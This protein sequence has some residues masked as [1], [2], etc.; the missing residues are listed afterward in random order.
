MNHLRD[1]IAVVG[2]ACRFP[3][4]NSISGLWALLSQGKCAVTRIPPDR[5]SLQHFGHPRKG[6][7]G[8]S[9][10]WAAGVLDDIWAFDP[11]VFG[12]SPREAEQM[13]PQQRILLQLTWEALEDAGI[14]PSSLAGTDVG[15]FVGGSL[16]EHAHPMYGDPAIADS[17][18]ATGNA[19]AILAN[20]ISYIFDLRGPSITIDTACSSS[21]VAVNQAIQAIEC[22]RIDTAIVGGINAMTA[23]TSFVSF[24][25]ASMLSPTG[26]CRAFSADAD[27]YVRAEGGGVVV[28]R[29]VA[30]ARQHLNPVHGIIVACDVSSDGRTNGISLP[31][32]QAQENL[33]QRIYERAEV[34]PERLAFVEA[35]GTGTPAGDPIEATALGNALG[36]R[37]STPLPIGSIKTNIGHLEPASGVAGLIKSL[38]AL[39]NGVL[40]ASLHFSGPNPNINF[41]ALNLTV[42][43]EPLKLSDARQQLAGVNSFGFGGTNAHLIL[44]PGQ[45][46]AAIVDRSTRTDQ[47]FSFS[48]ASRP[49]L[50]DFARQYRDK[51][52]DLSDAETAVIASA[53]AHRRDRLINRVVVTTTCRADVTAALDAFISGNTHHLLAVG[54][55][56]G[57]QLPIAFVYSGNGSQWSGMGR[58]SYLNS[59]PFRK[60]FDQI[61]EEFSG[62]AGWSLCEAIFD[63]KL[64]ERLVHTN[65]AQPLIF[66]IQSAATFALR[67]R[68]I[69]PV[70]I[71]GHSVGE[72]AAAEA[73][74]IVDL[75]SAVRIIYF[76]SK[77]QE[78]LRN[79]GR[80]AAVL[81]APEAIEELVA[82]FKNIEIAAYNGPRAVTIAGPA[83]TLAQFAEAA[84]KQ[85][86]PC[87]DLDLDYP[88]HT[89]VM[90]PIQA[91]LIRDLAGIDPR[92]GEIAFISTV[93]GTCLSGEHLDASYWW[94]NVREPVR[95]MTAVRKAAEFGARF[96]LEIGPRGV[97]IK[98]IS[99]TLAAEASPS[100]ALSVHERDEPDSI[101]PYEKAAAHVLVG[102]G[103]ID[104]TAIAGPDPG[105]SIQL[106]VYPWQQKSFRLRPTP[107]AIGWF[108]GEN[109]PLSG[110]RNDEDA[111]EWHAQIDIW[112]L[113]ELADHRLGEKVILPGTGFVEIALSVARQ[114]LGSDKIVLTDFETLTP[115]DLTGGESRESMT[116]ISSGSHTFEILSRPRLSQANWILHAR[117]KIAAAATGDGDHPRP[118][119]NGTRVSGDALY[120]IADATGLHY[121]PAFSQ[122]ETLIRYSNGM[123]GVELKLHDA[124]TPFMLD[125]MLLDCCSQGLILLF[126]ELQAEQRG[127]AYIPVRLD[128]VTLHAA[129]RIPQRSVIEVVGKSERSILANF[130]IF[131]SDDSIVATLRGVRCQAVPVRRSRTLDSVALVERT[132]P[133]DGFILGRFGT[134]A[135]T[136]EVVAQAKT[137]GLIGTKSNSDTDST[138]LLDG[139]ATMVGYEIA[140]TLADR[141]V[142]SPNH[143]IETNRISADLR[144]W[145][146]MLLTKLSAAGLARRQSSSWMLIEDPLLPSSASIIR[147][148]AAR[149]PEHAGK[150]LAAAEITGLVKRISSDPTPG[151]ASAVSLSSIALNFYDMVELSSIEANRALMRLLESTPQL[152]PRDRAIRVLQIGVGTLVP[153]LISRRY[154]G[155]DLTIFEANRR[156]FERE[157]TSQTNNATVRLVDKLDSGQYDVIVAA[158]TLRR[159]LAISTLAGLQNSLAPHGMLVAV[160]P[161]TS[162]FNEIVDGL[163]MDPSTAEN[164]HSLLQLQTNEEWSAALKA[165]GFLDICVEEVACGDTTAALLIGKAAGP[166]RQTPS[167]EARLPSIRIVR[168]K[169]PEDKE[170]ADALLERLIRNKLSSDVKINPIES[171]GLWDSLPSTVVQFLSPDRDSDS[172][173][174]LTRMCLDLKASAER[175]G[176]AA[177]TLW[178]LFHGATPSQG[179]SIHPLQR[180]AWAFSRTLA[181]EF[182]HL[183]IRRIDIAA[184]LPVSAAVEQ[185]AAIIQSGTPETELQI[186]GD[187]IRAVRIREIAH[188]YQPDV[189]PGQ[190]ARLER[191]LSTAERLVWRPAER[192]APDSDE[193]EIAVAATGL[194]FR[195]VMYM[196]GL[197]PDDIL[198][199][200]FTGPTLG[201]ECAGTIVATGAA[202]E[203]FNV[204]DRVVALA[205]L[206]FSTHVTVSSGQVVK[207]PAGMSFEAA[208][209]LP[210]AFITAYYSL[211]TLAQLQ[212]DEWVLIHAGAG[213]V[214]MAAIQVAQARGA[215]VITTAGG[216][217]KRDLL[218][219]FGVSYVLDSRS[220]RFVDEVRAITGAGV[221]IVLNSLAGDAMERSMACLRPFGR[222]IELG[223]RDYVAN[224]HIGLRPFRRNLSY[225]GVDI[226][227][228]MAS[229]PAIGRDVFNAVMR[230]IENGTF[231]PLPY[232]IFNS[233]MVST[234]FHLM[235]QAGHIG[236]I[237]VRPPDP[238]EIRIPA[239][240]FSINSQGTHLVTGGLGGFGL[241]AAKWLVDRGARHLVLVGRRGVATEDA[242]D[243]IATLVREGVSVLAQSC[244]VADA[245][246]VGALFEKIKRT[247]PP[248]AGVIHSA[249]VLDDTIIDNLTA[250]RF[251]PVL[252]PKVSGADHLDQ[253]TCGMRLDYFVLFSSVVTMIGN[254][255]QGSY[256][257][258]NG[259]LEGLAHRRRKAGLPALAIGW[260]PITDVGVV[261]RTERMRTDLRKIGGVNGL[262]AREALDL[263]ALALAETTDDP[264]LAAITIAPHEAAFSADILPIL[265]SPTYHG[266]VTDQASS[267]WGPT[268]KIDLPL[269]LSTQDIASVRERV[270][271][272]LVT[273]LSR[274]LLFSPEDISRTRP[275]PEMGLDSLMALEFTMN[276]EEIFGIPLSLTRSGSTNL[277]SLTSEI[278]A[279]ATSESDIR[280]DAAVAKIVEHHITD[281]ESR[282]V[283]IVSELLRGARSKMGGI[284]IGSQK[285]PTD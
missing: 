259:Y 105:G 193:I 58:A 209:T 185:I 129:G 212:R 136:R 44:A 80:M 245:T 79:S 107:E 63:E 33:L 220:T 93:T 61:D 188:C 248:I 35:H 119:G 266:L 260:G 121:G 48:A 87:L 284:A 232:S 282:Q 42:C 88:F 226:D 69:H 52:A 139:W 198:E 133:V 92:C 16:S 271:Q 15:V 211:I 62:L 148:L 60:R 285:F 269:L 264:S 20:R 252:A 120:R 144:S 234:A 222:F 218:R 66:A 180:G 176:S 135:T 127:V 97:L 154:T 157:K 192:R 179:G 229:R 257:A 233:A 250:E 6:E 10:T 56:S 74:G 71:L 9:Y 213:A 153:E 277:N 255:G 164:E 78:L 27:G 51:I 90:D 186:D 95:F 3:G 30:H 32:G 224:T 19:L 128:E 131:A 166:I 268:E 116:R 191:Q 41:D 208:A 111:L 221:D 194:N 49:A 175:F 262:A 270:A 199:D 8:R 114:W 160:E 237:V 205:P 98:H 275:L 230:E 13:D 258:A 150:L 244:D 227:Q 190:A 126:P 84:K 23:P 201:L 163:R 117:G 254:R 228:L 113:P 22:G 72:L 94:R 36:R 206:A 34:S 272:I 100:V 75:S 251:A 276:L 125:P 278:I 137:L 261:A 177:A 247:M 204:G 86:I 57:N 217:A 17:H 171:I 83:H 215:R 26:L 146:V 21:L 196:L 172:P 195:D 241:A 118:A 55:A 12:I 96:F 158:S 200:G 283:E 225:F 162:F 273:Q 37:R 169:M 253:A 123:I 110:A 25:Q 178:L 238:A 145:L 147:E 236:K 43:R 207:L 102:G 168:G 256:V 203:N 134:P 46:N 5:F 167:V 240:V 187:G 82:R 1:D 89:G 223:K 24:A 280:V 38:L 263:M 124:P 267:N 76:R 181:N 174:A 67:A 29:K 50:V 64:S 189:R 281:P 274:V 104:L 45:K 141:K 151:L 197:L 77:H 2:W 159:T 132:E 53:A 47:F 249:M 235:Q 231:V 140:A 138:M 149:Y 165:A 109:H 108:Q 40:P 265:K 11:D 115:L 130:Y 246:Q 156:R 214:G 103:K 39:N 182:Q 18:F 28:L 152:W 219:A 91:G 184:D 68:G 4:A 106:P 59:V 65:V 70:A 239:N 122:V 173:T 170:L 31:S 54:E 161:T 112:S 73:A 243:L 142:V 216:D 101:D 81:A 14:R 7:R 242:K 155:A 99:E 183:D 210:T 202:V 143:L 279:L 85:A